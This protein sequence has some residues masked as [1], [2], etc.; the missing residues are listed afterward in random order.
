MNEHNALKYGVNLTRALERLVGLDDHEQGTTRL[1]ETLT[2]VIDAWSRPEFAL[3]RLEI[4]YCRAPATVPAVAARNSILSFVNPVGSGIIA[5]VLGW[6]TYTGSVLDVQTGTGG[7]IAANQVTSLGVAQDSRLAQ[8]G[9]TSI[10]QLIT[11]DVAAGVAITQW[12]D[13][14]S[15]SESMRLLPQFI[16]TPGNK[17]DWINP[18]VNTAFRIGLL[19]SERRGF[20]GELLVQA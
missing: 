4:L 5:V 17:V 15:A 10:C 11:G 8:H 18:T 7:S 20:P 1:G 19:W 3:P 12:T 16:V 9:E 2:P 6:V 13:V 14:G